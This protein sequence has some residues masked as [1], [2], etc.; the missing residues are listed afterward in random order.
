[1]IAAYERTTRRP[2]ADNPS[3]LRLAPNFA[4]FW[5]LF[6]L[7][8]TDKPSPWPDFCSDLTNPAAKSPDGQTFSL[9][10]SGRWWPL[11]DW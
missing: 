3:G 6:K 9:M 11:A 4:S 8:A 7:G 1:M 10:R 5:G 2:L